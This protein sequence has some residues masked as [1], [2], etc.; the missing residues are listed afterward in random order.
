[1]RSRSR[2]AGETDA[3]YDSWEKGWKLYRDQKANPTVATEDANWKKLYIVHKVL[4]RPQ[5]SLTTKLRTGIIGLRTFLF[6]MKVLGT[7]FPTCECGA[8]KQDAQYILVCPGHA[9]GREGMMRKGGADTLQG[10]LKTPK[11]AKALTNWWMQRG[12]QEQYKLVRE[13]IWEIENGGKVAAGIAG[14]S[15]LTGQQQ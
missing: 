12:L 15:E 1:M 10:L 14:Q 9:E 2:N 6:R 8:P 3:A 11:G 13:M 7:D 5:S 4:V